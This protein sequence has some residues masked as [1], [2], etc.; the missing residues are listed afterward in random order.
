MTPQQSDKVRVLVIDHQRL[1]REGIVRLLQ[2]EP[3][4]EVVGQ[5][6]S[7]VD[8]VMIIS[9]APVDLVLLE[10]DLTTD[11]ALTFLTRACEMGFRGRTLVLANE[12]SVAAAHGLI[13]SGASG[14][15]LKDC[16]PEVLSGAIREAVG[17]HTWQTSRSLASGIPPSNLPCEPAMGF[18]IRQRQVLRGVLDGL[19]TKE[20]AARLNISEPCAKWTLQQIFRRTGARSR[21]QLARIIWRKY[22]ELF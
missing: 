10:Y 12:I 8:A 3:D 9:S 7:V 11:V 2:S 21:S 22:P 4:L 5:G 18:S 6:A 15:L 1:V 20:I 16:S 13:A 17:G 14:I 19:A